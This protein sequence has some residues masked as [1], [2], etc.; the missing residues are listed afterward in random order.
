MWII[1]NNVSLPSSPYVRAW[2]VAEML[3]FSLHSYMLSVR[4]DGIQYHFHN[5][6]YGPAWTWTRNPSIVRR[7]LC[8]LWYNTLMSIKI[9]VK[10]LILYHIEAKTTI[11][12]SIF[13]SAL[14]SN[15]CLIL[16]TCPWVSCKCVNRMSLNH[17]K[18]SVGFCIQQKGWTPL[19]W[20]FNQWSVPYNDL[21][22]DLTFYLLPFDLMLCTGSTHRSDGPVVECLPHNR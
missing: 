12:F 20:S 9:F 2:M 6:W 4:R 10:L 1:M 14:K 5:L 11:F 18:I 13:T 15:G 8:L 21:H 17:L 3:N 19:L 7:I 22:L 16:Y